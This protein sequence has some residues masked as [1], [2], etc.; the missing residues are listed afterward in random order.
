M[1][2]VR[3]DVVRA[4]ARPPLGRAR[5]RMLGRGGFGMRLR[6]AL[7]VAAAGFVAIL[8][9]AAGM[10]LAVTRASAVAPAAA[11]AVMIHGT[12]AA[13]GPADLVVATGPL[14]PYC[15]PGMMC[16]DFLTAPRR[17]TVEIGPQTVYFGDYLGRL[18]RS[19]LRPGAQVVVYGTESAPAQGSSPAGGAILSPTPQFGGTI[20]AEGV[21]LLRTVPRPCGYRPPAGGCAGALRGLRPGG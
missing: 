4:P 7:G 11:L 6:D 13:A 20:R 10:G 15:A 19:A 12:V 16:P 1:V 5:M 2:R 9:P 21:Y 3:A 17:Y 14:G 18:P 8:A